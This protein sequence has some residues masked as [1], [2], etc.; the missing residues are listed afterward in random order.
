[1]IRVCQIHKRPKEEENWW[2]GLTLTMQ[3]DFKQFI[4]YVGFMREVD[5]LIQ[6]PGLWS[7][8]KMGALR[9][10]FTMKCDEVSSICTMK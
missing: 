6:I 1:M 2:T 5:H 8:A 4:K 10:L 7:S 9:R 3:D